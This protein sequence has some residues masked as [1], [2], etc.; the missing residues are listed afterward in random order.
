MLYECIGLIGSLFIFASMTITSVSVKKNIIMRILNITG[1]I[2]FII[3]GL[4]IPAYS[5]ALVNAGVLFVNL[6]N[7]YKMVYNKG[8][9]DVVPE[10]TGE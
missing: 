4:L 1:S 10:K 5:T 7:I 2:F 9:V 3:Y 6:Y 8:D